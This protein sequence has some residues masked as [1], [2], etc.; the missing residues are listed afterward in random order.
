MLSLAGSELGGEVFDGFAGFE[1]LA[2]HLGHIFLGDAEVP[3]AARV[4]DE[5]RAVLAE[6]KA[7][8]GVYADVPVH[9]LCAQCGLEGGA[10]GLGAAFFAVAAFADEHVGVVVADLRVRLLEERAVFLCPLLCLLAFLRDRF[11]RF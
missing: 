10:D 2:Y 7:V 4:D 8:Y 5:V 1:G 11:L 3:G 9:V 6:A